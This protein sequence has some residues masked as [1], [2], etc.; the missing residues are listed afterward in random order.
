MAILIL[1]AVIA[2]TALAQSSSVNTLVFDSDVSSRSQIYTEELDAS[3][4]TRSPV[5]TVTTAGA[6]S[7]QSQEPQWSL[8]AGN[9]GVGRIAYQ[10]GASG[11]RGIHLIKPDGTGSVRLTP[12][13]GSIIINGPQ[14]GAAYPCVDARDPSWS[15]DGRYL[16]YACLVTTLTTSN[17]DIWIHS[18]QG[19][20]DDPSD[21]FDFPLITLPSSLELRPAWSPDGRTIAFVTSAPSTTSVG[22]NSK[23]AVT[24]IRSM[25]TP[26]GPGGGASFV[27]TLGSYSILTDDR[28]SNVSPSW[29]P[30]S[31]TI[32]FSTSRNGARDIYRMSSRYG[33]GDTATFFRITSNPGS[34]ASPA[35][36]PDGR[37]IAFT[38]D[39]SGSTQLFAT[40]AISGE[41]ISPAVLLNTGCTNPTSLPP[42]C[43]NVNNPSWKPWSTEPSTSLTVVISPGVT[44]TS[45][46]SNPSGAGTV[47]VTD[48]FGQLISVAVVTIIPP[49]TGSDT[50]AFAPLSGTTDPIGQFVFTV[51]ESTPQAAVDYKFVAVAADPMTGKSGS[52]TAK[53]SVLGPSTIA[54]PQPP[55]PIGVPP[56][57]RLP[58]G[59]PIFRQQEKLELKNEALEKS[60]EGLREAMTGYLLETFQ[61]AI[62]KPVSTP[63]DE[64]EPFNEKFSIIP[65]WLGPA[66]EVAKKLYAFSKTE[67]KYLDALSLL[68]LANDPPDSN[69]TSLALPSI[70]YIPEITASGGPLSITTLSL[71]N[72][73]LAAEATSSAYLDA[74]VISLNRYSAALSAGD[75]SSAHLQ[76][77]AI[78]AY[79]DTLVFLLQNNSSVSQQLF[80]SFQKDGF[81]DI[82]ISPEDVAAIQN[83]VSTKGFPDEMVHALEQLGLM[84]TD[85]EAI[86]GSFVAASGASIAG[87]ALSSML[88][89]VSTFQGQVVTV[90][91]ASP[92]VPSAVPLIVVTG[93]TFAYNGSAH[94]ARVSTSGLNGGPVSGSFIITYTPGG[95]AQPVNAGSYAVTVQFTSSDLNY[96]DG[97]GSGTITIT[98]PIE[99]QT[100]TPT[101][102]MH[103]ARTSHQTTVLNTG[104]VLASGGQSGGTAVPQS[105]LFNPSTG[106]WSVTGSNLIPRFDHTATLLLD[107]RVLAAGGVSSDGDCTSNVTAETYDPATGKWSLTGRIPSPVGTGHIAVRLSDGRVLVA[108]GGDRCGDVF[109]TASI[110]DPRTN[111]WSATGSM[112]VAREFHSAELLADSRV[113][114]AGGVTNSSLPGVSNAEVYDPSTGIWTPVASMG[115]VRQT[116]CN[117]YMQTYLASVSSDAVLAAGGFSGTNCPLITPARTVTGLSVTPSP[118]H[119][120]DI[121]Q[122]HSLTVTAQMSDASTP[123]FTGPLQFGSANTAV[124]SIDSSGRITAIGEGTTTIT[125]TAPNLTPVVVTTTVELKHLTSMTANLQSAAIVGSGQSLPLAINGQYSDGSQQTLTSGISFLSSNP[126]VA[127]VDQNGLITSGANGSA[128]I[129]ISALN[130]PALSVA[131]NVKSL[132]SIV[133]SPS[134][135]TLIGLAQV[136]AVSVL[137]QYSDG[138]Q[139]TLTAGLNFISSN[140]SVARVDLSGVITSVSNGS[141]TITVSAASVPPVQIPILVKSPASIAVTPSAAT[142]VGIGAARALAIT[143]M[144][145]DGSTVPLSSGVTFISS[146]ATIANVNGTGVVTS[147]SVGNATINA[148]YGALPPAHADITVIQLP[149][150]VVTKTHTGSFAQGQIGAPYTI[151]VT[152]AGLGPTFGTVTAKDTLPAGMSA[153]TMNGSGWDCILGTLT[154]TRSDVL[155]AG[156]SYPSI[157][158]TVNV[159]VNA[160]ES[161]TNTATVSGGGEVNTLNDTASDVTTITPSADL[162]ISKTHTGNFFQSQ[163]G[164]VYTVTVNNVGAGATVGQVTVADTLPTG[165]TAA[166]ISGSGWSCAL[167]T[168]TCTRNDVLAA[169]ANYPSITVTVNVDSTAPATVTNSAVVSGGGEINAANDSAADATTISG[170]VFTEYPLPNSSSS[171]D[172][173]ISGPDGNLWFLEQNGNR[174]GKI[175]PTGAITEYPVPTLNSRPSEITS[176][177]DGNL[178][179]TEQN[180]NKIGRITPVGVITEFPLF[181]SRSDPNGISQGPDGNLWFTEL[182]GNKIGR[183]TPVGEITEF[184]VPIGNSRPYDITVGSDGNL[185]FTEQAG[186]RIGRITTAG[187]VTE[188]PVPS[189]GNPLGITAGPDGNLWFTD[190]SFLVVTGNRIGKITTA[191]VVTEFPI[192]TSGNVTVPEGITEGTDGNL[193]FVEALANKLGRITPAGAIVEFP[194]PTVGSQPVGITKGPDGSL[195]LTEFAGNNI[196]KVDIGTLN[197]V[198]ADLIVNKTHSGNFNQGQTGTTYT[199]VV[200]NVG[201][202]STTGLVTA[203]DMLPSG[204][205]AAAISGI[206]WSCVLNSLTC[207]RIDSLPPAGSYPAITVTVNVATNASAS[208]TNVAT[209]SGGGQGNTSNDIASDVTTINP[210]PDLSLA[211]AHSGNFTR[212]Q[213]GAVYSLS[214]SNVGTAGTTGQV[215]VVDTMPTGLTATAISGPGWT[216]VLG[217]LKCTRS[218]V[219]AVGASYSSISVTVNVAAS[220]AGLVTNTAVV[221]GGGELNTSNDTANDPTV[222]SGPLFT[223]I[224][225]SGPIGI[226]TGPDG[227]LWYTE[228]FVS[229]SHIGRLTPAGVAT[230]FTIPSGNAEGGITAGP[231]GNLWFTEYRQ[232][233]IGRITPA[234]VITEFLIPT[235]GSFP[236][237]IA[238]GLDG[239]LWYT[240]GFGARN[241]GRITPAGVITEFPIPGSNAANITLGSDG[242]LWFTE[243]S[244]NKVGR[245]TPAG[246]IT[247]FPVLTAGSFPYDITAGPDGNLWFTEETANKIG[248]ITPAGVITEFPIPTAGTG[249]IGI[250]RGPDGNL[251]FTENTDRIG[252]VTTAGVITEFPAPPVGSQL[253]LITLGPDGNLWFTDYYGNRIVKVNIG[254]DSPVTAN[255]TVS[256][257]H[258]GNFTQGQVGAA[259][260][261]VVKN[262]GVAATKGLVTVVDTLPAGLTATAIGGTG[263]NC[264]LATRQC[265]RSDLLP[266]AGSYPSITLTVNVA[267]N[268]SS[269]QINA[270]FVFG[271]GS[272][273]TVAT[274]STTLEPLPIPVIS[275]VNPRYG[276]SGS[277]ISALTVTGGNLAGSTFTFLPAGKITAGNP[278]INAGGTQAVFGATIATLPPPLPTDPTIV[279]FT[280]VA[281]N[282]NG[283]SD[284][285]PTTANR[286][287][288]LLNPNADSDGDGYSDGLEVT[289]GSDP[290]DAASF[291]D[292]SGFPRETESV[293]FSAL[294]QAGLTGTSRE[295]SSVLFSAL[296]TAGLTS[297][298]RETES[299][300]FSLLNTAGLT[301]SAREISSV[302]FS[303]SN[304]AGL[305][306]TTRETESAEFSVCNGFACIASVQTRV[307]LQL[308]NPDSIP[309]NG[310]DTDGD[311]ISNGD[312]IQ[313]GLNPFVADSDGDGYPDGLEILLGSDP[314]DAH[315]IPIIKLPNEAFPQLFS[316][317]NSP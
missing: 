82:Q 174:I 135:L 80:A 7:Q 129:T 84:E 4:V 194:M 297:I 27:Q 16:A 130:V 146:D 304:G 283:S 66:A 64:S 71:M 271:G 186:D 20:S 241:I 8:A 208:V 78:L 292:S 105:E 239:N 39:R 3:Q 169:G 184:P 119:F 153:S 279:A 95:S 110:F 168:L 134:S 309:L 45:G 118:V 310:P 234:G 70:R 214:V 54:P 226:T 185:W 152:N 30:D 137:G 19:T 254:T 245:I 147:V 233:K 49:F 58:V 265:T 217:T 159:A 171:P 166:T 220:A 207:T 229:G 125:V 24:Q 264:V 295:T 224:P 99:T 15:P 26:I 81:P 42:N 272:P 183:I 167:G 5:V 280:L 36:S 114:V 287:T 116:S 195:W 106:T 288:V 247:E 274:D 100:T 317:Q 196:A 40:S 158:L 35:W 235:G 115:T 14:L 122:A 189:G 236:T 243:V 165:L 273:S 138:S 91:Q 136:Q 268:A 313:L 124:A 172:G 104:L 12:V 52:A 140:P 201:V 221:S 126:G 23:I 286:L 164:A 117:G 37:L 232:N 1:Y 154:C 303:V 246:L 315:S 56:Q 260:S 248:R 83:V 160:A 263:W 43:P 96:T 316:I 178:W 92:I 285:T 278:I 53:I 187:V 257:T 177:P 67:L 193:W 65:S 109:N 198:T 162:A 150:L 298:T 97:V 18:T 51:S 181:S 258:S 61:A 269:P 190:F 179:F 311:G 244:A 41:T 237:S 200:K 48:G 151:T 249:P 266:P 205:T 94:V 213:I 222:I 170:F 148:T 157:T 284:P 93:G 142:I 276:F 277:T 251:W 139:Q 143:L 131:I 111:I 90:S 209:V 231:D 74:L 259:Y 306:D 10:F 204:L 305:T 223:E 308:N 47:T 180:G 50:L 228:G 302:L 270:V 262:N 289:L 113:L 17:Y 72:R 255:L 59:Q 107:G 88:D 133:R 314:R 112:N 73:D 261:I 132:V 250:S 275:S 79:E 38:S 252:R 182:S 34:D 77:N 211:K 25:V 173:I 155:A 102:S 296:N 218:D 225:V 192:L 32:A 210:S 145:S 89:E 230:L 21:D 176:G 242:N 188:F 144:Y 120:S 149:D 121:G 175:T 69:F 267:A 219:L 29:A 33:E 9:D 68:V 163:T 13:F 85:V 103:V 101:G 46:I 191:G 28:F 108:G 206:G 161:L 63:L 86:R 238:A 227:N 44:V 98:R 57:V 300:A 62:G 22:P 87:G 307:A 212:S 127:S 55:G 197:P 312:E 31:Q 293:A 203:V 141:A 128:T 75:L 199:I 281:T 2:Q 202:A 216:C 253:A 282:V 301:A 156:L 291:P 123:L 60:R 76:R 256:K 6:G 215:T 11:V 294:N 290:L 299:V 240:V